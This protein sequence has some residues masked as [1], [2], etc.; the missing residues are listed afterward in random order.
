MNLLDRL[1]SL[2]TPE[3][4]TSVLYPV[5]KDDALLYLRQNAVGLPIG[6]DPLTLLIDYAASKGWISLAT[7]ETADRATASGKTVIAYNP[8][9]HQDCRQLLRMG[10]Y[11]DSDMAD[12]TGYSIYL[13]VTYTDTQLASLPK[14]MG[15]DNSVRRL[16]GVLTWKFSP[17]GITRDEAVATANGLRLSFVAPDLLYKSG[18][19]KTDMAIFRNTNSNRVP[20]SDI[21]RRKVTIRGDDWSVIPVTRYAA[22]MHRTLYYGEYDKSFCGTFYYYEPESSTFL[23]YKK[24]FRSFN[25]TT[26]VEAL[27]D[28]LPDTPVMNRSR[29]GI[30]YVQKMS[31]ELRR[32]ING[33][34]PRN[35][36]YTTEDGVTYYNSSELYAA[37]DPLDQVLCLLAQ[38]AG[39]DIV[40]LENMVGSFQ[41]VTEVLDVRSR[42]DSFLSLVYTY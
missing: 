16:Q 38:E 4:V 14:S 26:A 6:R 36:R 23:A 5:S 29:N 7:Q 21:V 31:P 22:G 18:R 19:P 32:H 8:H 11:P 17:I 10:Y 15:I 20:K 42:Y 9:L 41:V 35:L 2:T 3:Q 33:E 28:V 24:A 25:K 30:A 1:R 13:Y 12:D 39:Y 40:V 37:E 34:L 27:L